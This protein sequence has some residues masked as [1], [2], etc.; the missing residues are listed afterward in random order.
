MP[1]VSVVMP[2][3]NHEK[4]VGEA[5][6]S[7]LDQSYTDFEFL[8]VE[9]GCTDHSYEVIQSFQDPRIRLFRLEKNNPQEASKIMIKNLVG[10][11]SAFICSD[12]FW[13]KDKLEK[14]MKVLEEQPDILLSFTWA[15]FTDENWNI[16][17]W[18][19]NLF[20]KKNR[21][22]LE[23]I[24]YLLDNGNCLAASSMV[25]ESNLWKSTIMLTSQY[26]QLTDYYTWLLGLNKTNIYI[27]EEL[28]VKQRFHSSVSNANI[29]FP[30]EE[31]NIRSETEMKNIRL[32]V[33]EN[34]SDDDFL[35][36]YKDLLV[37]KNAS[38]HLEVLCEKFFV[39]LRYAKRDCVLEENML[40]FFY[41]YYTYRENGVRV[42]DILKEKYNYSYEDFKKLSGT[43]GIIA[44]NYRQKKH[45]ENLL[46][47]MRY[48]LPKEKK[49]ILIKVNEELTLC[50]GK[51][52][53]GSLNVGI[54]EQ[55]ILDLESLLS[56][57]DWLSY[58]EIGIQKEELDLCKQLCLIYQKDEKVRNCEE[59]L[60]NI[61]R[62]QKAV[63]ELMI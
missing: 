13:E 14:Q 40:Y 25:M 30:T 4:Y 32:Q 24:R 20:F 48:F 26:W 11:Y 51:L 2:C 23:W 21:S 41:K 6:K 12:D 50:V 56:I 47:K 59:L 29:S 60:I 39:F 16:L 44:M 1:K 5:I 38:T 17:D 61:I 52:Q 53:K 33:I 31:N 45:I 19:R 49:E 46:K 42:A 22:R 8:I 54:L 36:A 63:Q 43:T 3:Y 7:V 34:L 35:E 58:M 27:V 57:W 37:D 62:Y 18:S 9:N 10:K 15:V 28:L 55:I